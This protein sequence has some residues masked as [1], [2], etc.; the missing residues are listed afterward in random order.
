MRLALQPPLHEV[1]EDEEEILGELVLQPQEPLW[2]RED[3]A[4]GDVPSLGVRRG[5]GERRGR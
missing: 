3:H 4:G 1:L 5:A 2:S